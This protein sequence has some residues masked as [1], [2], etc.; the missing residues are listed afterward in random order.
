MAGYTQSEPPEIRTIASYLR[1]E[2]ILQIIAQIAFVIIVAIVTGLI[3]GSMLDGLAAR[4]LSPNFSFIND[5]KFF[6]IG[7]APDWYTSD[8]SYKE[9]FL[10]GVIN[11]LRVVTVGLVFTTLLGVI[12]GI[13]L[14]SS[15]WVLRTVSRVYVE[16]LRNIPLLVQIFVWFFVIVLSLPTLNDSL[17]LPGEGILFLPHRYLLYLIIGIPYFIY[18]RRL[19]ADQPFRQLAKSAGFAALIVAEGAFVLIRDLH[20]QGVDAFL[21][22][23]IIASV[24]GIFAF[25]Q[26]RKWWW[27]TA[28]GVLMGQVVAGTLFYLGVLPAGGFKP[29][30][31]SVILLNNRGLVF[32]Q[33]QATSRFSEWMAFVILGSLVAAVIWLYAA[34][35]TEE[36]GR[37]IPR[38]LYA[39]LAIAIGVVLGWFV[40]GFEPAPS[41]IAVEQD[42]AIVIMEVEEAREEALLTPEQELEL[43][44]SPLRVTLP[45]RR[46]RRF[47]NAT[48]LTPEYLALL[49]ALVVYTSAFIAEIVRAGIQAVPR[50][51]LEAARA[52]GLSQA[53]TLR[54]IIL[55]QALR[56]I[57]PPLGNQ[58]LNLSKNSSLAIAIGF[59]D[60]FQVSNTIINQSGQSV[61]GFIIVLSTYLLFSL[62]IS[63][64]MNTVNK[65][66]QLVTR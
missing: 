55:P 66:F 14:L 61:S 48:T 54:M 28:V 32:P 52:V 5:H 47:V 35:I 18:A 11:T 51:Q 59:A 22:L 33:I 65:R 39:F 49:M 6:E 17:R 21:L 30:T 56:V 37:P 50:G 15:N 8:D 29:T 19:S 10:V 12:V 42:G 24:V 36:T 4:N 64:I 23:Y 20:G 2:R 7:E 44:S 53:Q 62:I 60:V 25:F 40:V 45:E 1:D 13:F 57:I 41:T 26:G 34:R 16:I 27:T 3:V 38:G 46:G 9:A 43:T 58:Y 63:L 31:S